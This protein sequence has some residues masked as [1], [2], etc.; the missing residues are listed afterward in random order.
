MPAFLLIQ[1][2][3]HDQRNFYG[4]PFLDDKVWINII[5]LWTKMLDMHEK[6]LN[7]KDTGPSR[8]V[9]S[10]ERCRPINNLIQ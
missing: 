8:A 6:F 3:E 2:E 5:G 9:A 4:R 10:Y 7:I 1:M